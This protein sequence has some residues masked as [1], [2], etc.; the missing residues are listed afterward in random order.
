MLNPD[1]AWQRRSHLF[2]QFPR[3]NQT[4]QTGPITLFSLF[5]S[6]QPVL[7]CSVCFILFDLFRSVCFILVEDVSLKMVQLLQ[8]KPGLI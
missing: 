5:N 6:V 3:Q 2:L 7:V 8:N 4:H 1:R